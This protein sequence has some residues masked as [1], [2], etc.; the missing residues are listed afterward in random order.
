VTTETGPR[1]YETPLW[2]LAQLAAYG[3]I[4]SMLDV[5]LPDDLGPVGR[6]FVSLGLLVATFWSAVAV[7]GW[8]R[9]RDA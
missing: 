1:W 8:L 4:V 9:R 3:V 7:R 5:L 6:T 2:L